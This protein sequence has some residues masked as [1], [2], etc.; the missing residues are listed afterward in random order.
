MLSEM[1]LKFSKV[2]KQP[3][4]ISSAIATLLVV[5]IQ[6]LQM[7]ETLELRAYDQMMQRRGDPDP[8]P[9]LLIVAVTEEDLKKWNHPLSGEV[10][11]RLLGTLEESAPR[12]IGLDILR[13]LPVQPGHE[14]LLERFKYSSIIFPVCKHANSRLPGNPPPQGTA[15]EQV[16]FSDVVEDTDGFIRRN[17]ISV[18][19]NPSD[20]CQTPFSLSWQLAIK[21]LDAGGINP[22]LTDNQELQLGDVIFKPL[23]SHSGGYENADAQG[24]QILLN[25]RSSGQIAQ[26]V[27]VTDVLE[28][29]VTADLVKDRI[30]LIGSTAPSL[31]DFFNTPLT[32]GKA[33]N[34]GKMAGVELHA[35]AASQII[36]AVVDKRPLF[37]FLPGWGEVIW[38]G[39]WSVV[40][41]FLAW[42]IPNPLGL[43]IATTGSL[44]VLFGGNFVIF[45]Q[46]GWFP[47]VA[48]ALS[49]VFASVGVLAYNAYFNKQEQEQILQKLEE[50]QELIAKLRTY[51]SP[52]PSPLA[53]ASLGQ[54]LTLDSLLNERYKIK[55]KLA[56]GGFGTTYLAEDMQRPGNPLCVVKQMRPAQQ[57][58]EYLSVLRRLFKTEADILEI[59]GKHPHI[60]YLLAFLEEN[61]QFYLIQEFIDGHS[62]SD[63]LKPEL[64]RSRSQVIKLIKE[65]LQILVFVHSYGVI[66]RDVKPTNLI[67]RK[68]DQKVVLIDFGAVK[69]VQ[70]QEEYNQSIIIGTPAYAAP[71]QLTGLPKLNGDIYSVGIIAIQALTGV[72]PKFF[73]RDS[74]TGVVIMEKGKNNW[75]YW[76]EAW[77]Q[78]AL[79]QHQK[80]IDL[81]N[82]MVHLDFTQRYQSAE[83]VLTI[84]DT[85]G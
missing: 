19:V 64:Q 51:K 6:K 31:K 74:T 71:E 72:E 11:D 22:Q 42:R 13:D 73:R 60:P 23:Q 44:L 84:L 69:Q 57:D 47:V 16:G 30:V 35:Q 9:R 1:W 59:L 38:I 50:Q 25:Y 65:I 34:D 36:S 15:P 10:L 82:K 75:L 76:W 17:L 39:A 12:A 62:V 54:E 77:D 48:P 3:V 21:F 63:E 85:L 40:G 67:R 43:G 26:Q 18:S 2:L 24:Y 70:P 33:S 78:D 81:I 52:T 49:L 68:T 58:S 46:A 53:P 79:N 56:S 27:T 20:V 37:W 32:S 45:T 5:G 66:H 8:D 28:G 4:I 29:Q 7:L 41:G 83:E 14:K 55:Q 61:E 80:L